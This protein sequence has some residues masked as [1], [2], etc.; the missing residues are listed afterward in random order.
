MSTAIDTN[1]MLVQQIVKG[2]VQQ[3]IHT[4]TCTGTC[5]ARIVKGQRGIAVER[6]AIGAVTLAT[7]APCAPADARETAVAAATAG[8]AVVAANVARLVNA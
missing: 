4:K 7:L 6:S 1:L 3:T 8:R 2:D 5:G